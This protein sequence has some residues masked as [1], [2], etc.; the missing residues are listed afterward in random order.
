MKTQEQIKQD[1]VNQLTW[2]SRVDSS[3][4]KVTVDDGEVTLTGT[5]PSYTASSIAWDIANSVSGVRD[6]EN[7]LTIKFP[8]AFLTPSDEQIASNIEQMLAWNYDVNEEDIAVTVKSGHVTLEG[9]VGSFWQ[10]VSAESDAEYAS[11]VLAVTNKLAVVPTDKISD[12]ILGERIVNR[13]ENSTIADL[14]KID[15][16]V[17]DGL[18]TLTGTV[19]SWYVW[20][21]VYD[22]VQYTEGVIAIDDNL[23][24]DYETA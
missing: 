15:I 8:S 9:T 3:N 21:S 1:I 19:P 23:E 2:D 22:A 4:I 12:K 14:D 13:I 6:V 5:V 20:N 17:E 11:G 7:L 10:K 16:V 24:I 18:V